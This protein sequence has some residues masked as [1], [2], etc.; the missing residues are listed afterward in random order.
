MM[1]DS[2]D[3]FVNR[4]AI[5]EAIAEVRIPAIHCFTEAVDSGGLIA[6]AFDL[7]ELITR[8]GGDVDAIL[9]GANPAEIPFYQVSK[10]TCRSTSRPRRHLG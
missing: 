3:A 6:Y 5:A 1:V 2:P 10:L 7:K 9:R 8:V 4:V